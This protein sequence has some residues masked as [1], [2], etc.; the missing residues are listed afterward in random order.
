MTNNLDNFSEENFLSGK[1]KKSPFTLPGSYFDSFTSRV[2]NRIEAEQELAEFKTL[3]LVRKPLLFTIPQNYFASLA[4]IL[5][6][7]Y[8]LSAYTELRKT[9]KPVLLPLPAD[10]FELMEKKIHAHMELT[11]E[12]KEFSVLSSLE[13]KNSFKVVAE[14]FDHSTDEVKEKIQATAHRSAGIFEQIANILFK[15]KTAFALSFI[16]IIGFTSVWYFSRN[17]DGLIPSG[18]C[19]TLACL[20]KNELLNDKNIRDFDDESLYEMVDIEMLDKQMAADDA[21]NDSL[22]TN[23]AE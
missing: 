7:K 4:N 19:K 13:K 1:D 18:D 11:E 12:L 15:P 16:L 17:S 10:Y 20:E 2:M 8:E 9:P 22:Q 6:Y 5:E 21:I 23:G 3:A 14:Y